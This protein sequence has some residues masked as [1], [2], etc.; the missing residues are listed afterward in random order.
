[1]SNSP[2]KSFLEAI[3]K[4]KA[5]LAHNQQ[6]PIDELRQLV[7]VSYACSMITEGRCCELLCIDRLQFRDEWQKWSEE[8]V[9]MLDI[10]NSVPHH[11]IDH[12][13]K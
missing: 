4:E 5:R 11:I 13:V 8:N 1:M 10:F 2:S 7:F 3:Q 6:V 9:R 12:E